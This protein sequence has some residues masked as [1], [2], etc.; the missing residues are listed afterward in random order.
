MK[1]KQCVVVIHGKRCTNQRRPGSRSCGC[2]G[3]KKFRSVR[4]RPQSGPIF[5]EAASPLS[6]PEDQTYSV[7]HVDYS[8]PVVVF[9]PAVGLL[10]VSNLPTNA[11]ELGEFVAQWLRK[12]GHIL[13]DVYRIAPS[14]IQVW[15][16]DFGLTAIKLLERDTPPPAGY[17]MAFAGTA[18]VALAVPE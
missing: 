4:I 18:L 7:K 10:R 5:I 1:I 9:N 11:Q 14:K 12:P 17:H 13:E 3:K 15:P 2:H 16:D 6:I 8:Y